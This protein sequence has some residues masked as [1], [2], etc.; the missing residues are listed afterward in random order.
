MAVSTWQQHSSRAV[1]R[2]ESDPGLVPH[3]TA[4]GY[5]YWKCRCGCCSDANRISGAQKLARRKVNKGLPLTDY[6]RQVLALTE[7]KP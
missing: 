2:A 4:S 7:K 5:V 6:D 3:G 1:E